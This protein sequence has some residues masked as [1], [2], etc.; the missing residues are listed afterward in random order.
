M[1]DLTFFLNLESFYNSDN[2]LTKNEKAYIKKISQTRKIEPRFNH[3][4]GYTYKDGTRVIL[5]Y[6][7]NNTW[8]YGED[9][10]SEQTRGLNMIIARGDDFIDFETNAFLTNEANSPSTYSTE[11]LI[12]TVGNFKN[13]QKRWVKSYEFPH[14]SFRWSSSE[15]VLDFI[16]SHED[17]KKSTLSTVLETY[18][19]EEQWLIR[20]RIEQQ[21]KKQSSKQ[22]T[23][24]APDPFTLALQASRQRK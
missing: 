9:R 18:V 10:R 5:L 8:T 13:P 2:S 17:L 24:Q 11:S 7:N 3:M 23:T 21:L 16:K 4:V 14:N 15:A 22:R 20:D 6:H 12:I 19:P 1:D